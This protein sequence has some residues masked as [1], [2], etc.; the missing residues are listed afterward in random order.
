MQAESDSWE[1]WLMKLAY[2]EYWSEY[3]SPEKAEFQQDAPVVLI[4]L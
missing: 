2:W 3:Q 1:F 4:L